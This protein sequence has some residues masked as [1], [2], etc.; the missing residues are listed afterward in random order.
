MI[1]LFGFKQSVDM[2]GSAQKATATRKRTL[3]HEKDASKKADRSSMDIAP[4]SPLPTSPISALALAAAHS[5]VRSA[6][7]EDFTLIRVLGKGNFGKVTI[8]FFFFFF[9]VWLTLLAGYLQ[10]MLVEEKSTKNVY[11]I[12][13]L[14]KDFIIENDEVS[15]VKTEKKVFQFAN[16][17]RHPFL[18]KLHSCFQTKD[19]IFFVMEYVSG[20]DLMM[21]I[22]RAL[23]NEARAKYRSAAVFVLHSIF[24]PLCFKL[25]CTRQRSSSPS[26]T[27]TAKALSTATSNWT[28]FCSIWTATSRSPTMA[29]ARR[30]WA[31]G[32]RRTRSAAPPS[33]WH[34]RS[35]SSRRTAAPSTGGPL[36]CLFT[37]CCSHRYFIVLFLFFPPL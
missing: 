1:K 11:A 21:H 15:S 31:L 14:K 17:A 16:Q 4:S 28:T 37:R 20:G 19:R 3:M 9:F 29:C 35:C 12:K 34:Q 7:M 24:S 32:G 25:G 30:A 18:V 10:V 8:L 2:A 6:R 23:F 27:S 33:L 13:V 36:V 26:S 22:Q 5:P